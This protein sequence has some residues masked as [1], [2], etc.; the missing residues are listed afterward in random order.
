M[1]TAATIIAILVGSLVLGLG[2]VGLVILFGS[3]VSAR[4]D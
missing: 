2:Y 3:W 4:G 1:M